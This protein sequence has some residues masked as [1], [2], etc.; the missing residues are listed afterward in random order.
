[1]DKRTGQCCK[2]GSNS[3]SGRRL[4]EEEE[5]GGKEGRAK[6]KKKNKKN[7]LNLEG[8][9]RLGAGLPN[10]AGLGQLVVN[11]VPEQILR[12]L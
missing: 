10:C 7:S 8:T 2:H 9:D 12:E 4:L 5:G 3:C 11:T 6:K 1:M